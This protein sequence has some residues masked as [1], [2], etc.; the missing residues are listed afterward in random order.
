MMKLHRLALSGL[1]LLTTG[2]GGALVSLP[3]NVRV[4][5][6]AANVPANATAFSGKWEGNWDGALPHVLVV[7][8]VTATTGSVIYAWGDSAQWNIRAGFSRQKG[9]IEN[10]VLVVRLLRPATATY[11]MQ[12]NGTLDASYEWSGGIARATMRK[13]TQ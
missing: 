2:C 8:E 7:E 9:T 10:N 13:V 1:L 11:R 6:P 4:Q 5:A 3:D 12:P